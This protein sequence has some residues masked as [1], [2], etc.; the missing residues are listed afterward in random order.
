LGNIVCVEA[1]AYGKTKYKF[2]MEAIP[3]TRGNGSMQSGS[4][5]RL[6]RLAD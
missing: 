4:D 3:K 2:V 1:L 5:L 6:F